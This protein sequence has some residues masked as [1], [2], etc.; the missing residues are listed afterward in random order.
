MNTNSFF[1]G[2]L[3]ILLLFSNKAVVLEFIH[4][5]FQ[6][7]QFFLVD[8]V[9]RITIDS[10]DQKLSWVNIEIV[11]FSFCLPV[12]TNRLTLNDCHNID[13]NDIK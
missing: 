2:F 8:E 7:R 10:N 13:F 3:L 1:Q 6:T 11:L 9:Y 12:T 4:L 5:L